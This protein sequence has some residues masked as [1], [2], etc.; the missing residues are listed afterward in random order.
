M[1][2]LRRDRFVS[3][4]SLVAICVVGVDVL[5]K[6]AAEEGLD[7]P[8]QLAPFAQLQL[9][10]NRG[11]AF[12]ALGGLPDWVVLT[13]VAGTSAVF[14]IAVARGWLQAGAVVVGLLAGGAAA[15]LI[16]RVHD[17]RVTDYLHIG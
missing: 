1:R 17:G 5:T 15:N 8:V 7:A 6:W 12:G 9:G 16:D 11:V 3:F 14:V 10:Y 13:A 4:A 2:M